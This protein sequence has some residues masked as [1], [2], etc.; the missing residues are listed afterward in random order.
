MIRT[1]ALALAVGAAAGAAGAAAGLEIRILSPDA[2]RYALVDGAART[3]FASPEDSFA[4]FANGRWRSQGDG[5]LAL[6][7]MK[8]VSGSDATFGAYRGVELTWASDGGVSVITRAVASAT[9]ARF[10]T[11]WPTGAA[12]TSPQRRDGASRDAVLST[13]PCF[14][15]AFGDGRLSW[16]G[17]FVTASLGSA[18]TG[19]TG[20]P[21]V[22]FD[23]ETVAVASPLDQ[24]K[25]SSAGP[26]ATWDGRPAVW[27]PGPPAT[28]DV[29]PAN[30]SQ[31]FV[32]TVGSRGGSVVAAVAEWGELLQTYHDAANLDDVTL[33]KVGYQT[34]NGA[35]YCFCDDANCSDT[36]IRKG[37]ELRGS[38]TGSRR[39][40]GRGR[41]VGRGGFVSL[42][43][44]SR[45]MHVGAAASE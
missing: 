33:T 36:L 40:R 28:I 16:G 37:A 18:T 14:E 29:I 13:W 35:M 25:A 41:F 20:G 27:A 38:R 15:S 4:V 22:F 30:F 19:P 11:R 10:E 1:L 12:N 43:C 9:S 45:T 2:S 21:V 23:D 8:N 44:A 24:F 32:V 3:L 7:K 39:R 6:V 5:G 17:S 34:D 31:S 42:S 26:G